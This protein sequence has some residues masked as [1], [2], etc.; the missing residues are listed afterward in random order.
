M[1]GIYNTA[2]VIWTMVLIAAPAVITGTL[3]ALAKLGAKKH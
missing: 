2:S 1:F 3:Y